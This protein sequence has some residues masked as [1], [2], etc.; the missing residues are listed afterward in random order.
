MRRISYCEA[1]NEAMRQEMAR[2]PRV[3]TY[4]IGVP[5]H[6][7]IFGSTNGIVEEFGLSRCFDT[8]LSEDAMTGFGV[9]AAINGLRPIHVH[10]RVDFMLLAMNQLAN[11]V[12]SYHYATGG[13]LRVPM[14]IRVIIGRG[15]GQ[16]YQHSKTMH[17]MFA[18]IPGIK[19][20]LPTTPYDVKGMMIEA[21][22][23]DNPVIFIEHRWLYYA[24]DEV[25][26]ESYTVP[27][28]KG[29]ILRSGSD[30]SI[31]ATSWM[32]V[33]ALRAA[34]VLQHKHGV[35]LEVVDPRSI[36]PLDEELLVASVNKTGRCLVAD[37][38]WL[39]C[40]FGAEVAARISKE[41]FGLLKG[42]V[43]RLGFAFAPCPSTRPL[44]NCYYP[45]AVTII[46]KVEQMLGLPPTDVSDQEFF[47][48]ERKFRGPY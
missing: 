40:G 22:R 16:S 44:E 32:N 35:S 3:F 29:N 28:G 39:H 26:E 48:Y 42:P 5:D 37:Y 24:V 27:L 19:V 34:D 45:D 1:L 30:L 17:S 25:P 9:G 11:M 4:G 41:C 12:S 20:V 36:S 43:D 6:K 21:V 33:E 2:D 38:D 47:S 13:R 46:R 15:W 18:H 23:D 10:A 14:V 8:P 31:I 7:R